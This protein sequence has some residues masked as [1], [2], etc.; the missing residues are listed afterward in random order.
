MMTMAKK[1][2]PSRMKMIAQSG[3]F[4]MSWLTE[5]P[6]WMIAL[7]VVGKNGPDVEH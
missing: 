3:S 2:E 5:I 6:V 1:A 7:D 4:R